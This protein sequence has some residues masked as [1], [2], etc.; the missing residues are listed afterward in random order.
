VTTLDRSD[1]TV[2][3]DAI[4]IVDKSLV[5]VYSCPTCCTGDEGISANVPANIS[6]EVLDA[7]LTERGVATQC[8]N[9]HENLVLVADECIRNQAQNMQK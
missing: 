8:P 9:C 7:L 4:A 1:K 5:L 2:K 6:S 3:I